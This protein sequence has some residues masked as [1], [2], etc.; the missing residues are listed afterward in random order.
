MIRYKLYYAPVQKLHLK[1]IAL[2]KILKY[3]EYGASNPSEPSANR[4]VCI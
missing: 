4:V 3:M 2:H 1:I